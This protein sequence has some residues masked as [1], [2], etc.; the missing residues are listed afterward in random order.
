MSRA[1][2][3]Y[4]DRHASSRVFA[5]IDPDVPTAGFYRMRLRS[6]GVYVGVRIWHG[7]PIDPASGDEM[8]RAPGWNAT[9][10]GA[11]A[12]IDAVWPK[13]GGEPIDRAEHD[14]LCRQQAWGRE[15]APESAFADPTMRA[16]PLVSPILF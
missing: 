1:A 11:W 2:L 5:G 15:H 4:A 12:S 14:H 9:I 8:D 13:C 6:G 16:D 3:L 7:L 10:N